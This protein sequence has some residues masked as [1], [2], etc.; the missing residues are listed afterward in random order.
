[1]FWCS[2]TTASRKAGIIFGAN[3]IPPSKFHAVAPASDKSYICHQKDGLL[4]GLGYR[5]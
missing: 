5:L 1:M 2:R 4:T 3:R